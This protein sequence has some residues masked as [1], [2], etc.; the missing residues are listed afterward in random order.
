MRVISIGKS[1]RILD[2]LTNALE[3]AGYQAV[4]STHYD[5]TDDPLLNERYDSVAFGRA[6]TPEMRERFERIL[7]GHNPEIAS[8]V[9]MCPEVGVLVG[10]VDYALARLREGPEFTVEGQEVRVTTSAEVTL[11]WRI[12]RVN[13]LFQPSVKVFHTATL[14]PGTHT[15]RISERDKLRLGS[16]FLQ[17]TA[18]DK[19]VFTT[20]C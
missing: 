11:S 17:V 4:S 3:E 2:A 19:V 9:G 1:P 14:E 20:R 10:Q 18:D 15:V 13:L 16:N 8:V 12:R 5:R 6:V 7:R